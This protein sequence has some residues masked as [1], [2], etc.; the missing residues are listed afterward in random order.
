MVVGAKYIGAG[1]GFGLNKEAGKRNGEKKIS[2]GKRKRNE[3]FM[4]SFFFLLRS[5]LVF[6]IF[7]LVGGL[8]VGPA[9]RISK[10][11]L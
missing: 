3:G 7:Y 9:V 10:I 6:G 2:R 1:V 4:T 8:M 11:F 5:L